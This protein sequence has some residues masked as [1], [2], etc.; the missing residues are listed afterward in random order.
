VAFSSI[1]TE[2]HQVLCQPEHAWRDTLPTWGMSVDTASVLRILA[3]ELRSPAGVAQGYVKM[4]L[5][6]R[7]PSADDQ[8]RAL[9][10]TLRAIE[11]MSALG[12]EASEIAA[13]LE[14][15]TSAGWRG[16]RIRSL[17]DAALEHHGTIERSLGDLEDSAVINT[18]NEGALTK[19]LGSLV[20]AIVREAP[21]TQL[22]L[23]SRAPDAAADGIYIALGAPQLVPDLLSGPSAPGAGPVPLERGGL[24]LSLVMAVLVLQTHGI[25]AWTLHDQRAALGLK[26]PSEATPRVDDHRGAPSPR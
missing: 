7:L 1:R 10:Q 2:L 8:R 23:T 13:W 20:A 21:G 25:A 16:V 26:F 22:A 24:G 15:Q 6:G 5:E 19:A 17:I 18:S 12:R 11:R 3:H 4:A 14:R 9:E